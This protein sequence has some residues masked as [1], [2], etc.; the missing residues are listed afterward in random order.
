MSSKDP[1][2]ILGVKKGASADDIKR[3]Y[4]RLVKEYHPDH[5]PGN[6]NAERR[7]KEVQAAWEVLGDPKRRA[8]YDRYGAGGPPPNFQSWSGRGASPFGQG[9]VDF[10]N[11]GD[12]SGI[13]EQFFRRPAGRGGRRRAAGAEAAVGENIEHSVTISFEEA[14]RGSSREVVLN[15]A[16]GGVEK[17]SV[18]LPAGISDGQAVRVRGRGQVGPGGRGDLLIRA[19]IQPH[20]YFR[21]DGLDILLD[22]PLTVPEAVLGA[23][24]DIPTLDGPTRLTV[25]PG[26]SSGVRLRLRGKGIHDSRTGETGDLNA[27]VKI[28]LPREASARL[29][30][31]IEEATAEF[32]L[33]HLRSGF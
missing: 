1:Y 5:N 2:E 19:R 28:V 31:L 10:G 11:L 7:F 14:A 24:V 9:Q 13:F 21:R 17:L 16:D 6:R 33:G 8:E 27:I 12:L 18:K 32:G 22:L 23:R 20:P 25:P 30:S 29:R 15:D 26:A 3:A 4:R